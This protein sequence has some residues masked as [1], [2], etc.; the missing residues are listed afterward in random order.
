LAPPRGRG[1]V[2]GDV[3][4]RRMVTRGRDKCWR[5]RRHRG[6]RRRGR[7]RCRLFLLRPRGHSR[8]TRWHTLRRRACRRPQRPRGTPPRRRGRS[9]P[10]RLRRHEGG[11]D[12][13]HPVDEKAKGMSA[14]PS[15][16]KAREGK[17]YSPQVGEAPLPLPR[18]LPP[19]APAG[20][21]TDNPTAGASA[22]AVGTNSTAASAA[23]GDGGGGFHLSGAARPPSLPSSSSDDEFTGA[24]G[25]GGEGLRCSRSRYSSSYCSRRSRRLILL[26]FAC[27]ARSCS[28]CC[29]ARAAARP[30]V[31]ADPTARRPQSP[32][33]D[34]NH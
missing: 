5:H 18:G 22:P 9:G 8:V 29:V 11:N 27:A 1:I 3:Y 34:N 13:R 28:R 30:G 14:I 32:S 15:K 19:P 31:S 4:H 17:R 2:V 33:A 24:S 21:S 25:G 16:S 12:R 6:P 10:E 23:R 7:C 26:S 20:T